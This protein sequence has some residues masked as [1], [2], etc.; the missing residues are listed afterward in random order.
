MFR[1][2]K[3]FKKAFFVGLTILSSVNPLNET[4]LNAIPLS[5]VPLKFVSL[6]NEEGKAR[7]KIVNVNSDEPVFFSFYY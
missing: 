6:N 3:M 5:A 2:F 4:L 1:L 7:L